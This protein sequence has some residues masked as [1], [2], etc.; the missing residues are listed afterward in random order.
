M[1]DNEV[2]GVEIMEHLQCFKIY[3]MSLARYLKLDKIELF[4]KKDESSIGIELKAIPQ[5]L[6]N[7]DRLKKHQEANNK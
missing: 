1:V 4:K 5:W 2:V 7:K 6:V 3:G